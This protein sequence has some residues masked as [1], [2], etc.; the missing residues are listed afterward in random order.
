[1]CPGKVNNFNWLQIVGASAISQIRQILENA[2]LGW[3][4]SLKGTIQDTFPFKRNTQVT[5]NT[6]K[7]RY[8]YACL[9]RSCSSQTSD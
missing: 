6:A 1:M 7:L 5:E 4:I 2:A 8:E 3:T 9:T